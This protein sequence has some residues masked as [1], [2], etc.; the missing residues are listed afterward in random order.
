M[1]Y[2]PK[3]DTQAFKNGAS[4][5]VFEYGG[6]DSLSGA[7]AVINGRYPEA[8]WAMNER[9]KEMVYVISGT[10]VFA[11]QETSIQLHEA[12]VVLIDTHEP[13][14]FEG[15]EL[16]LFMPTTPAWTPDQ[17]KYVRT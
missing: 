15:S 12:D 16:R 8:G 7:V 17:Y 9:S 5:V 13:Y 2:M 1:K 11:T 4:C 10:G 6:D 14:S 3:A